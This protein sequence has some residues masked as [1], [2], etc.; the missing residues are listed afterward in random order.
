[1]YIKKWAN[2]PMIDEKMTKKYCSK[3][4]IKDHRL[5]FFFLSVVFV[6]HWSAM[7]MLSKDCGTQRKRDRQRE[8]DSVRE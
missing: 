8:R 7:L 6:K 5:Y 2:A 4:E 1:M 3:C